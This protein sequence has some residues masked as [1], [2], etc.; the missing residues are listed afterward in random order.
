[1]RMGALRDFPWGIYHCTPDRGG[2]RRQTAQPGN[3]LNVE[4][5]IVSGGGRG[6][7]KNMLCINRSARLLVK[8]ALLI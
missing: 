3:I 1:M 2:K 7:P 5:S 4:K 6:D 8:T